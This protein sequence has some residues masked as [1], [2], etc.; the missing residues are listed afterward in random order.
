[1][2]ETQNFRSRRVVRG[3]ESDSASWVRA[4]H[5]YGYPARTTIAGCVA[6]RARP[7]RYAV[8]L[9]GPLLVIARNIADF[10]RRSSLAQF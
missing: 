5:G 9:T 1:M 2:K 8:L 7:L 4:I 3:T 6:S 10:H